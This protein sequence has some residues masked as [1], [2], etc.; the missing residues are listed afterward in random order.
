MPD[1]LNR[2]A[3]SL[4]GEL[5]PAD[6]PVTSRGMPP[7][8]ISAPILKNKRRKAGCV[9]VPLESQ[10][11]GGGRLVSLSQRVCS[12]QFQDS[13]GCIER[14]RPWVIKQ[15]KAGGPRRLSLMKQDLADTL[16]L[17]QGWRGQPV[18]EKA[19]GLTVPPDI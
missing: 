8:Q 16:F 3:L 18:P 2:Q 13:R 14:D 7:T 12:T 4:E 17:E 11:S 15:Q 1:S 10:H 5:T 6:C 19:P 9:G